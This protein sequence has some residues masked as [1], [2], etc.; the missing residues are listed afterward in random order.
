MIFFTSKVTGY[1]FLKIKCSEKSRR[2]LPHSG[3]IACRDGGTG[4]KASY[5]QQLIIISN[6]LSGRSAQRKF[7]DEPEIIL[8]KSCV[9]EAWAAQALAS[10]FFD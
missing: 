6:F 2:R 10:G 5:N 4:R 7:P 8:L 1:D 3:L 9:I